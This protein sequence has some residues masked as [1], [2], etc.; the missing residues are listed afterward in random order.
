LGFPK[1]LFG[2]IWYLFLQLWFEW[3]NYLELETWGGAEGS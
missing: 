1:N 3:K 2:L